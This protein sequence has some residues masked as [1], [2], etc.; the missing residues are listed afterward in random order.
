[1]KKLIRLLIIILFL[2]AGYQIFMKDSASPPQPSQPMPQVS[3]SFTP[4]QKSAPAQTAPEELAPPGVP[5]PFLQVSEDIDALSAKLTQKNFV[6]IFD[7]SGSMKEKDCSGNRAK[8]EV[9]KQ[10]V[11]EWSRSVPD[12]ANIGLIVFDH[13]AFSVRLPL[14]RNN[15]D[16]FINE[17][18]QVVADYKTPLTRSLDSA[19]KMLTKQGRKQLGYGEYIVVIVTDGAA[20]NEQA[21]RRSVDRVLSRSPIMIHTIGFCIRSTHTLNSQ[22]RTVYKSANNPDELQKGLQEVLAE[23]ESYDI[24][25]F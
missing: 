20:N 21:L 16:Q 15:R 14:G 5:W 3:K 10:A 9:A 22:G 11:I 8:I 2:Y 12:D 7:G 24:T 4:T 1:M 23:S 19:Y 6:L 13:N 25:G 17:I 18:Q